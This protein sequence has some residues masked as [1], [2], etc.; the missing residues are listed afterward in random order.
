MCHFVP[1]KMYQARPTV[2]F[3]PGGLATTIAQVLLEVCLIYLIITDWR[4]PRRA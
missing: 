2:I 4:R 3:S 1:I